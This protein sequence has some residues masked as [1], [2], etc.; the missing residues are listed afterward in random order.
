MKST[1]FRRRLAAHGV[2]FK[3]GTKHTKLYFGNRQTVLPRHN[4]ELG[5][6]LMSRILRQLG[7]KELDK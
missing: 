2:K 1:E 4:E 6:E 3:E 7:V 5:K